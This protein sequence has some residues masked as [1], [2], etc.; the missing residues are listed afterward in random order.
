MQQRSSAKTSTYPRIGEDGRVAVHALWGTGDA[1][2]VVVPGALIR[3]VQA[4]GVQHQGDVESIAFLV[5]RYDSVQKK[6][7]FEKV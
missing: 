3:S 7:L 1:L 2:W 4:V 6:K 5:E